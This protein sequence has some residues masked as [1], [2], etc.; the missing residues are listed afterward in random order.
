MRVVVPFNDSWEFRG[1]EEGAWTKVTLPHTNTV[2][3][4]HNFKPD[5]YAFTS[6]YRKSFTLPEKL[7]G[8][9][10]FLEFEGAM[11]AATCTLNGHTYPEHRGGYTPFSLDVTEIIREDGENLVEVVLDSSERED[12][13]PFGNVVDYLTFGGIYREV[14]LRYVPKVSIAD[15]VVQTLSSPQS[16]QELL[17][18][19][20]IEN[21]TEDEEEVQVKVALGRLTS[22]FNTRVKGRT[23]V[24]TKFAPENPLELWSISSPTLH[25]LSATINSRYGEDEE[26][27]R[28]GIRHAHFAKDG[29]FL[30]G[31]KVKL[32]GLNRHQTY[33]YIGAA[34]PARLQRK[35]ADIVKWELGCNIVRTSHYPQ[36]RHFLD[37]CDEIGLLVLE[38]IPGWQ[39]I[40]GSEWQEVALRDV[41]SM[42]TRDKNHPSIVLWGVRINE[43]PDNHD[44]YSRSNTIA[45]D[46]DSSRQTGG[47]RNFQGSEFLEDVFT[48]NDFSNSV[49]EPV[50]VPH[51]VTE[52]NG[53]MFPTKTFDNEERLIEHALRHA[54]V[55]DKAYGMGNVCGAIGWCAF[56]Y[57]THRDF[58]SGDMICYHG[59]MDIFRLPKYAAYFYESQQPHSERVVLRVG[60][61]WTMGDRSEGGNDPLVVF[62]NCDRVRVLI[63]DREIGEYLPDRDT[64]K[65]LPYPPFIIPGLTMVATWGSLYQD[66]TVQGILH[67]EVVAEKKIAAAAPP[68]AIV[69]EC[70][71]EFL[72]ADGVDTTRV[73][74]KIVDKY[75]NPL[76]YAFNVVDISVVFDGEGDP[77]S[78][79]GDIP[80]AL[81]G[82]QGAVYLKAGRGRGRATLTARG[83]G[84]EATANVEIID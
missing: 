66:L 25:P 55:Q 19:V 10:L 22:K 15:V 69:L 57:N 31:E 67:G 18:K 6:S 61:G 45:R 77:P 60:G 14:Q 5:A 12:I 37:R 56:D 24:E 84:F 72:C 74:F 51:L 46:L 13:P 52:F 73:V 34:A 63:G 47:I 68:A 80:F 11:I 17:V 83:G 44:F 16:P 2:L 50:N 7:E 32:R 26:A 41:R 58:G 76:R 59:V 81:V 35:D 71:D 40:G 28:I 79:I 38:E 21:V 43:S 78:L 30:N 8:R 48:Y 4:Y 54:R 9:R 75:G 33:P 23:V 1:P 49:E 20:E 3:P 53:H 29:F 65:N 42:I 82:G 70:D 36:S 64:Y 27:T 39:H 62:S